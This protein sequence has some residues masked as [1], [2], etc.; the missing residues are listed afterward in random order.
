MLVL[1]RRH[2]QELLDVRECIEAVEAAF[3]ARA[4]GP[5]TASAVAGVAIDDG[6]LHAKLATLY[7]Q[8]RYAVAKV[9]ANLPA[10]PATR[11]LPSIQGVLLLFD[12][13][14][15]KPLAA[16]DSSYLTAMRTAAATAV[17]AKWLALPAASS[18]AVIGCGVQAR[19]HVATL[20]SVRPIKRVHA[21]DLDSKAGDS[22]C[23]DIKSTYDI[24][25]RVE[26]STSVA[27]R[28][29]QIVV[30]L[31]PSH[32]PVIDANDVAAGAFVAAVGADSEDKHEIGLRLLR[33]AAIV[34]DDLSQCATIGDLH[35]AIAAGVLGVDDVR[36]SLD[37]IV[38]GHVHGR[39]DDDEIIL[40]DST[41]VAIEDAAAAAIVYEKAEL[42]GMGVRIDMD[43]LPSSARLSV[44]SSS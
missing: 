33:S 5:G 18:L 38:G 4:T 30:T 23:T 19:A 6:K 11:G 7:R 40:F 31:T 25:C 36:A 9:N 22:F 21:F 17:A 42:N 16:M 43:G 15:G 39:T 10:N 14:T 41:G 35:H 26:P 24:D 28:A 34:V 3:H 8:R 44:L 29:A 2:V 37:Q 13:G 1:D 27:T 20:L 12:A 32:V